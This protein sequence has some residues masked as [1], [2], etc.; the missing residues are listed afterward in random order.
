MS[1]KFGRDEGEEKS[2]ASRKRAQKNKRIKE[3][4]VKEKESVK[5]KERIKE[6]ERVKETEID[7]ATI[8]SPSSVPDFNKTN[9]RGDG[10]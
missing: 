9:K 1:G 8:V 7:L 3:S 6:K 5:E 2:N 4:R 10:S